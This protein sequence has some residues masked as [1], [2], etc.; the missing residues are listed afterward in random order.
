MFH[1][2]YLLLIF[3]EVRYMNKQVMKICLLHRK[4]HMEKED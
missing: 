2:I 1:Q 4:I 3:C